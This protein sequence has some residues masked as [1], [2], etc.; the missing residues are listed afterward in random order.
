MN[1]IK[2]TSGISIFSLF[3]SVADFEVESILIFVT[4]LFKS[5][6]VFEIIQ[7]NNFCGADIRPLFV[8]LSNFDM[9]VRYYTPG[10]VI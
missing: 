9:S 2:L 6:L 10:E 8:Q 1:F 5:E 3:D 4:S 7:Y